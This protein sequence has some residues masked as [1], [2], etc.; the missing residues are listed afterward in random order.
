[1]GMFKGHSA[2]ALICVNYVNK[3]LVFSFNGLK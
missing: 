1:M 3:Y 2:M